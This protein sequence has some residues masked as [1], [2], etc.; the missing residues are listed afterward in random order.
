MRN[1]I[2]MWS[3][4]LR[5][6][7]RRHNPKSYTPDN[8]RHF[9]LVPP[10][11]EAGNLDTEQLRKG[12]GDTIINEKLLTLLLPRHK[13]E[14]PFTTTTTSTAPPPTTTTTTTTSTT[15]STT[16]TTTTTPAPTTTTTT[17][18]APTTTTTELP[19]RNIPGRLVQPDADSYEN[20]SSGNDVDDSD[21]LKKTEPD[22]VDFTKDEQGSQEEKNVTKQ[23]EKSTTE[24]PEIEKPKS[25]EDKSNPQFTAFFHTAEP[26]LFSTAQIIESA[27]ESDSKDSGKPSYIKKLEEIYKN[28][29]ESV[30][31]QLEEITM[32][33]LFGSSSTTTQKPTTVKI[34]KTTAKPTK[35]TTTKAAIKTTTPTPKS[36]EVKEKET[37]KSLETMEAEL[38]TE[39]QEV[40]QVLS[41]EENVENQKKLERQEARLKIANFL[42]K[43]ENIKKSRSDED[44]KKGEKPTKPEVTKAPKP[45]ET[46]K[47]PTPT[48]S[49]TTSTT[50]TTTSE[51]PTTTSKTEKATSAIPEAEDEGAAF[52]TQAPEPGSSVSNSETATKKLSLEPPAVTL[53]DVI[54]TTTVAP[55]P[56]VAG[57]VYNLNANAN[58]NANPQ[59]A[60]V[61]TPIAGILDEIRP[62]L[63]PLLQSSGIGSPRASGVRTYQPPEGRNL[64]EDG[65]SENSLIGFGSQLAREILNPGSLRKDR[66]E[67]EK[68][69]VSRINEVKKN[70]ATVYDSMATGAPLD[71]GQYT[72]N[73]PVATAPPATQ[74]PQNL[75]YFVPPPAGYVGP[76]PPVP[77]PPPSFFMKPKQNPAS[78]PQ[79]QPQLLP[80]PEVR[81][82]DGAYPEHINTPYYPPKIS[83]GQFYTGATSEEPQRFQSSVR[84]EAPKPAVIKDDQGYEQGRYGVKSTFFE[85]SG[86]P[87]ERRTPAP[88]VFDA[89]MPK[90]MFGLVPNDPASSGSFGGGKAPSGNGFGGGIAPV[91]SYEEAERQSSKSS[92]SF[93]SSNRA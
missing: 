52:V 5:E 37:T 82:V 75:P 60:N 70:Q 13:G 92:S 48:T 78:Q 86:L 42:K 27:A 29:E 73:L 55:S 53:A 40:L 88:A 14:S 15:T 79:P 91:S 57:T 39:V 28:E 31:K 1:A 46:T 9:T 6:I 4:T 32:R 8:V 20:T 89:Q 66:M 62:I 63:S 23:M 24:T 77:P 34:T 12:K 35:K 76:L 83:N 50:T 74:P 25:T 90:E 16:T 64:M 65:F 59:F 36:E 85:D 61:I 30:T 22:N 80:K 81:T 56:P 51:A 17:T 69:I 2:D 26:K 33:E 72:Q 68:S 84:K 71:V 10:N 18:L 3:K 45:A 47:K 67:R 21:G 58:S 11:V 93:F 44:A 19:R 54:S 87:V 7:A 43:M 49:T 38:L 41:A